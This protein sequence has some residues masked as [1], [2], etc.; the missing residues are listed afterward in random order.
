MAAKIGTFVLSAGYYDAF[1][2]K[3]CQVRELLRQDFE[4]AFSQVD[5]IA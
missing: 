2:A 1:Y 3:A 5:A 4:A